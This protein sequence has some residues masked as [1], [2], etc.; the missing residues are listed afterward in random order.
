MSEALFECL[1]SLFTEIAVEPR[2]QFSI[3]GRKKVRVWI[4]LAVHAL[5]FICLRCG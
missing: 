1:G 5:T 3:A 2:Q 4:V